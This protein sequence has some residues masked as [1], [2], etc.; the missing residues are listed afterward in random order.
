MRNRLIFI[1]LAV[2]VAVILISIFLTARQEL[3]LVPQPQEETAVLTGVPSEG[4]LPF[5]S[6]A[7]GITVIKPAVARE[8]AVRHKEEKNEAVKINAQPAELTEPQ[9][10]AAGESASG[11]TRIKKTPSAEKL[12][13]MRSRGIV[14]F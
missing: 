14:I 13:E 6:S 12:E 7:T 11:I 4:L 1:L 5:P 9:E 2:F 10:G 8:K 3:K